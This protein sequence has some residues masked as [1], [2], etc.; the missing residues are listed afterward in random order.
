MQPQQ[1]GG[2][3]HRQL[4]S[5]LQREGVPGIQGQGLGASTACPPSC[6]LPKRPCLDT[7]GA[8][9]TVVSLHAG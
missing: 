1:Q 7:L 8:A 9:F 2:P 5:T 4:R 6:L 3:G